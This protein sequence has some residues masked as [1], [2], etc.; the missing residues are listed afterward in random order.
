SRSRGRCFPSPRRCGSSRGPGWRG[1]IS[2]GPM[3][4]RG[5]TPAGGAAPPR[6]ARAGTLPVGALVR[7]AAPD[8]R[9]GRVVAIGD[10]DFATNLH[11]GVLGNRDLLLLAA[12]VA[13]RGDQALTASRKRPGVS[14]PFSTLALTA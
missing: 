14:G 5:R 9:E 4:P 2:P 6:G 7:V 13:A 11:L 10:A 1:P 12:E 3:T 8:G